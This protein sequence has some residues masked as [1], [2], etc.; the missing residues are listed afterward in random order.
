MSRILSNAL[1][2]YRWIGARYALRY[3]ARAWRAR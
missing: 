2:A 1:V 3:M